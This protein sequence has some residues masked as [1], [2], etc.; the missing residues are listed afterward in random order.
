M[1]KNEIMLDGVTLSKVGQLLYN[2][3]RNTTG[4]DIR[5]NHNFLS[6]LSTIDNLCS[7]YKTCIMRDVCKE[8]SMPYVHVIHAIH[9]LDRVGLIETKRGRS[10][11]T[12]MTITLTNEGK[13][14]MTLL[15]K[16]REFWKKQL[17]NKKIVEDLK[18]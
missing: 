18:W 11:K 6:V 7:R 9:I 14:L 13:E 12:P 8:Q 2:N 17:E 3:G 16:Q 10:R 5:Q 4:V 15:Q 1:N